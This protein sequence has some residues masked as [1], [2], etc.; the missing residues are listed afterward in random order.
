MSDVTILRAAD[1]VAQP[2]KNGGGITREVAVFPPGAGMDEFEW[3]VSIADVS[4]VGAFSP[5]K[6]VDRILTVLEGQLRLDIDG[7]AQPIVLGAGDRHAFAGEAA[8]VGTPF[9]KD[10]RDLNI[11]T[12]RGR[13]LAR[14]APYQPGLSGGDVRV[15]IATQDC[16]GLAQW[17]GLLLSDGNEPPP[18]FYGYLIRLDHMG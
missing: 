13:W 11:M 14:I 17:D 3:R 12:R 1:R 18:G 15:A 6:G 9:G 8:V 2:W 16:A 5:F 7:A 4:A 10:V